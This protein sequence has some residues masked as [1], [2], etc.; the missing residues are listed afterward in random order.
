MQNVDES[1]RLLII[2]EIEQLLTTTNELSTTSTQLTEKEQPYR[3]TSPRF[4]EYRSI[5]E[6]A[7]SAQASNSDSIESDNFLAKARSNHKDP[8]EQTL[9]LLFQSQTVQLYV[10]G[11]Q[12]IQYNT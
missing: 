5:S 1:K 10:S 6:H 3:Q 2:L 11:S 8:I 12:T 7:S 9:R 4:R